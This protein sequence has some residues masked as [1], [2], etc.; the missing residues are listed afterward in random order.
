MCIL[1]LCYRLH[2]CAFNNQNRYVSHTS[3]PAVAVTSTFLSA[4]TWQVWLNPSKQYAGRNNRDAHYFKSQLRMNITL[5]VP[6]ARARAPQCVVGATTT[7][8]GTVAEAVPQLVTIIVPHVESARR[9]TVTVLLAD[10]VPPDRKAQS[11]SAPS[12]ANHSWS[13]ELRNPFVPIVSTSV[14]SVMI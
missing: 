5:T 2:L 3:L 9:P 11:K 12:A 6:S 14:T 10:T 8:I 1:K 7:T 4:L 13:T